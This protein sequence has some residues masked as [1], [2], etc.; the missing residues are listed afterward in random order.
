MVNAVEVLRS[1][2]LQ[3]FIFGGDRY[4]SV[5][6]LD[7]GGDSNSTNLGAL[8]RARDNPGAALRALLAAGLIDFI[9]GGRAH[10]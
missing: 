4:A 5:L 9:G 1:R 8:R 7:H 10:G 6:F 3:V 2:I